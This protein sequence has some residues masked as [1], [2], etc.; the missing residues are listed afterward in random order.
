MQALQAA[1]R[2]K[3]DPPPKPR[4][5]WICISKDKRLPPPSYRWSFICARWDRSYEDMMIHVVHQRLTFR[6]PRSGQ[7]PR[8]YEYEDA[9]YEDVLVGLGPIQNEPRFE[10]ILSRVPLP[11]K[12]DPP[13]G[14][15]E[16]GLRILRA[17]GKCF[18]ANNVAFFNDSWAR[19]Y[20][21][22]MKY[23]KDVE[24]DNR[25]EWG[26]SEY[27]RSHPLRCQRIMPAYKIG[28]GRL[29]PIPPP[30]PEDDSGN[31]RGRRG[32]G[33]TSRGRL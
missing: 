1:L 17:D 32:R 11:A 23:A 33:V 14:W 20:R 9:E 25:W 4:E 31:G 28:E 2:R 6:R 26:S 16:D 18:E 5:L 24:R 30:L 15:V 7:A 13:Y 21:E 29:D 19:I 10:R 3:L 8:T 22:S 12:D 27:A